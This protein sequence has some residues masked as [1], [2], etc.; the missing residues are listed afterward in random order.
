VPNYSRRYA[1]VLLL[2]AQVLWGCA[3]RADMEQMQANQFQ[4]RG[5]VASDRQQME[6]FDL[7]LSR[8]EDR[9][10][11]IQHGGGDKLDSRLGAQDDRISK[12]EAA[13]SALQTGAAAAPGTLPTGAT[14]PGVTPPGAPA[15]EVTAPVPAATATPAVEAPPRWRTDLHREIESASKAS[16]P[17]LKIYRLGL[18]ALKNGNYAGAIE[19]FSAFQKK[20]PK[21]PATEPAEYFTANAFYELGKF[22]QSILQF[23]DLVMRFP[24]GRFAS[25][26][27][28]REAQAFVQLKDKI[29]AR[30]TLQKLLA[31]HA[32]A[33]EAS[34][35]N[36]ILRNLERD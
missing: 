18:E 24:K 20:N 11:E 27:L 32:D 16:G 34:A 30:L 10:Q 25:A 26:A 31:D 8:L 35:A 5:M 9:I 36:T 19:K 7:R 2:A 14:P 17:G 15:T 6:K 29:D 3:P 33:P 22:D 21:S 4:M 1:I 13:V 28:L 23:N 12:L